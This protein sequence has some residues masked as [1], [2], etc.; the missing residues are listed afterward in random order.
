M[1]KPLITTGNAFFLLSSSRSYKYIFYFWI[2]F[3]TIDT[4]PLCVSI[5]RSKS[6]RESF[7]MKK[8]EIMIIKKMDIRI[9]RKEKKKQKI[10]ILNNRRQKVRSRRIPIKNNNNIS[11]IA[12][13]ERD[14]EEEEPDITMRWWP[15][16]YFFFSSAYRFLRDRNIK[17]TV[18]NN[19]KA[20]SKGKKRKRRR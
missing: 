4:K 12:R 7:P 19:N 8:V 15:P 1:A 2:F 16:A 17:A 13:G 10:R 9:A 3:F 14:V 5:I 6:S 11:S 20:L 18:Y